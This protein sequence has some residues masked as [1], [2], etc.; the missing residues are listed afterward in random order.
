MKLKDHSES[1]LEKRMGPATRLRQPAP[2]NICRQ[3][4]QQERH[5]FE[6]FEPSFSSSFTVSTKGGMR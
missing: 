4:V 1:Q 6:F 2:T 3:L 5:L